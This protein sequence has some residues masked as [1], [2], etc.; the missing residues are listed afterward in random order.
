MIQVTK[1]YLPD[2]DKYKKYIDVIYKSCQ[3]TN[4]GLLV[5]ELEEKLA[6]YLDVENIVLVANGTLALSIAYRALNIKDEVITTPFS[7]VATTNSLVAEGLTPIF[8]DIN[9]DTL[10]IDPALIGNQITERKIGRAHV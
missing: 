8:S 7:F 4:N 3:L 2:K 9:F 10:N 5:Q 1:S 6:K